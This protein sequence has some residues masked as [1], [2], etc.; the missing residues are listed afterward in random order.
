MTDRGRP[1]TRR[2]SAWA[3]FASVLSLTACAKVSVTPLDAYGNR[4]SQAEG[5]RYYLPKPYL[6]VMAV[7]GGSTQAG[8]ADATPQVDLNGKPG[9]A[10]AT[11]NAAPTAAQTPSA[12]AAA[13]A[14]GNT[15]YQAASAQYVAKLIYLP[16]YNHPM[17][18]SESSGLFGTASMAAALQDGWQLTSLQG[19][20]DAKVAETLTAL[21]SLVSA[22]G[23]LPVGP[24]R[25][26]QLSRGEGR[27]HHLWRLVSCRRGSTHSITAPAASV[28]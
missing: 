5:L 27:P 9:A 10:P 2:L 26:R 14:A 22:A 6:L 21:A 25:R 4:T 17:A 23:E 3:L 8:S 7:P 20:S 11:G 24:V 28:A 16:D 15:S 12:N 13:P 19:N 1:H 18:V